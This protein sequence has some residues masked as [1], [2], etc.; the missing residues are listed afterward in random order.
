[1][2]RPS[3]ASGQRPGRLPV[4]ENPRHL[5]CGG[6]RAQ[7]AMLVVRQLPTNHDHDGE[8]SHSIHEYQSDQPSRI[9]AS[10]AAHWRWMTRPRIRHRPA[11]SLDGSLHIRRCTT[12]RVTRPIPPPRNNRRRS[13][14]RMA[15][16][17]EVEGPGTHGRERRGRT[18]SQRPR[19]QTDHASRPSPTIVRCRCRDF[20]KQI[21]N[22]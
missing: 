8:C 12:P 21:S 14:A 6:L 20:G 7:S 10:A 4:K 19:R 11:A 5:L 17:G 18:I 16:N 2:N 15:P 3:N 13:D 22:E 9:A 1:M